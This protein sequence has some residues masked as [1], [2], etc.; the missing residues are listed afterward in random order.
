ML[1]LSVV[2]I[3]IDGVLC[4]RKLKYESVLK[5]IALWK[6]EWKDLCID[7]A[8]SNPVSINCLR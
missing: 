5:D 1:S 8:A 7:G 3:C 2:M 4:F 6:V